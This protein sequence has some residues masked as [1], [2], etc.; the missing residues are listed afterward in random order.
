MNKTSTKTKDPKIYFVENKK[1]WSAKCTHVDNSIIDEVIIEDDGYSVSAGSGGFFLSKKH[2]TVPKKG[3]HMTL[4]TYQG[5]CIRGLDLNG[6]EVFFNSDEQ[7]D[8]E[9][10]EWRKKYEK[11]KQETFE[12]EK[13]QYDEQYESLPQIFKDR[14]DKFRKDNPKFRV[15]Y[16]AYELFT[17]IE[18]VK[19]A[20]TLKTG[21]KIREFSECNDRWSMVPD[22]DHGHSGNTMG[23]ATRL[24]FLYVE[25]PDFVTE[26]AGALAPLVGSR[27]YEE[28][29]T[30]TTLKK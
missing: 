30:R 26:A 14:I 2:K 27:E 25:H 1:I 3:D 9:H 8:K 15:D 13:A 11:E 16:E 20:E 10:E 21:D 29:N 4:Y 12:R 7:I 17:C 24:A 28:K 22:L 6:K 18:A 19:I 5:S 23:M